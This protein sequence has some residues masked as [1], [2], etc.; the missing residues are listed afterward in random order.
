MKYQY[1]F[2]CLIICSCTYLPKEKEDYNYLE[3]NSIR[4]I[5][6]KNNTE[7]LINKDNIFYLITMSDTKT[8]TTYDYLINLTTTQ[9]IKI[10]NLT[11][12]TDDKINILFNNK[13]I[14]IYKKELD[15]DNYQ[16]CNFIYL[17]KIDND[18][19]IT[20]YDNNI[21]IYDAYTNFNY[22]FMYSLAKVWI[23]TIN[24]SE[25]TITTIILKDNDYQV[26]ATK[27]RGKTIHKKPNS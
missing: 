5:K 17:H 26:E 22:K 2:I 20:L 11:I 19:N 23:D 10:N 16:T 27:I 12:Y 3:D 15:Q 21:L 7:I 14:C 18:F 9:N 13:K 8:T 25:D 24:I 1:L 6:T 4:F